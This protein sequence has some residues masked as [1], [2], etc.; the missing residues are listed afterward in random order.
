[1]HRKTKAPGF[2]LIELL[3]VIAIIAILA[4]ILFPVFLRAKARA[5]IM[6]CLNNQRQWS[7]AMTMYL[8]DNSG[9][10][11]YAGANLYWRHSSIDGGSPTCYDALWKYTAKNI[12]IRWCPI[13]KGSKYAGARQIYGWSY[14]Y[15]C[16]HG[17][18]SY[19][20]KNNGGKAALC[21]YSLA[22]VF[23]PSK[24]PAVC[25]VK[26]Y[27][28]AD[29]EHNLYN[30]VYC[31]GHAKSLVIGKYEDEVR[32]LYVGRDGSPGL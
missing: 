14:W 5:V 19:V 28:E 9:R 26:S 3:V 6:D 1:M 17:N 20:S 11:P 7:S 15:F 10:F 27:H 25:E 31:D 24:K 18:N 32:Y 4:A 21:G 12:S 30:V 29:G 22:D 16:P 13:W 8:D 23:R 2:T